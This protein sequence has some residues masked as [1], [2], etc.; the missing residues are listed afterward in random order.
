M[1][2]ICVCMCVVGSSSMYPDLQTGREGNASGNDAGCGTGRLRC[3]AG[4][5]RGN[6]Y[7]GRRQ[8]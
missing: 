4:A 2:K 8:Q 1:E 6:L 5:V 3:N 7:D